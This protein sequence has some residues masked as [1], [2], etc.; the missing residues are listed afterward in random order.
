MHLPFH[1]SNR[2]LLAIFTAYLL[3][4]CGYLNAQS[5]IPAEELMVTQYGV[6]QGLSQSMVSQVMQDQ[7]GLIWMVSGEGLNCFNGEEFR[8]FKIPHPTAGIAENTMREIIGM[9]S[10]QLLISTTSSIVSFDPQDGKFQR[11][12]QR[13]GQYPRIFNV[14]IGRRSL[15]WIPEG[16]YCLIEDR[17]VIPLRLDVS[18]TRYKPDESF[19]YHAVKNKNGSVI[20]ECNNGILV[21]KFVENQADHYVMASWTPLEEGCRGLTADQQ[22][23][24]YLMDGSKLCR[25]NEDGT[26]TQLFDTRLSSSDYL[27]IDRHHNFWISDKIRKKVHYAEGTELKEI[28]FKTQQGKLTEQVNPSII[29]IF[30]DK[31]G[32]LWFGTDGD[33]VLLYTPGLLRFKNAKTGF[34]RSLTMQNGAII[35]GTYGNGLWR[36]SDDLSVQERIAPHKLP[37]DLYYMDLSCDNNERI[38]A[39]TGQGLLVINTE[40]QVIFRLN[41]DTKHASFIQINGDTVVLSMNNDL[42][43]IHAGKKPRILNRRT[44]GPIRSILTTGQNIWLGTPFGLFLSSFSQRWTDIALDSNNRISTS[45][46]FDLQMRNQQIWVATETGLAIYSMDGKP[47]EL[48]GTLRELSKEIFYSLSEDHKHRIWFSGNKG[49]GCCDIPKNKLVYFN[50]RN[51]L[52]SLEFNH[53]AF[54][55]GPGGMLYFGGINGVNAITPPDFQLERAGPEA[56]LFSLLLSDRNISN[57]IPAEFLDVE[58]NRNEPHISGKV[59]STDYQYTGFQQYSFFL[60]GW[61]DQWSSP[62]LS[63]SFSFRN[64]PPG[65][66][67]LF[68]KCRDAFQ[69]EGK[70]SLLLRVRIN[71][72]FWTTWWFIAVTLIT[73]LLITA[74]VVRKIQEIRYRNKLRELE[75]QNAINKERL[76]ISKDMHDEIGASLT[77]ISILSELARNRTKDV[78]ETHHLIDQIND[79]SGNVVDE[80]SEIIWAINPKN[81]SLSSF[82]SYLR[83]YASSYLES[84][85]IEIHYQF[86]KE[87]PEVIMLSELRRNLFLIIKEALHNIVKHSSARHVELGISYDE[88]MLSIYIRDNG[89]GFFIAE[90]QGT[91]NGLINMQKRMEECGGTL[92]M[93]SE[94]GKGCSIEMK[95]SFNPNH[96]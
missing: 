68:V 89:S 22:G 84:T 71:P 80:I 11:L 31:Q 43:V 63:A 81:D 48:K 49:I 57:G 47:V 62:S 30:E 87:F 18:D 86:R 2:S 52:Q 66:Y 67:R 58:L 44:V 24:V 50:Q 56:R 92:I 3:Q 51:N 21:F 83:R 1:C 46:V 78:S 37:N 32:N 26:I 38:W 9:A 88:G 28:I 72:P 33:G 12:F 82:A 96:K 65:D 42:L 79:I 34:T 91:G 13:N 59:F 19:P 61:D 6:E 70:A 14:R 23:N 10:D 54:L 4:A 90:R 74:L 77:R 53:N 29:N 73:I 17:N 45:A 94:P 64:L 35:A 39:L 76:R 40:D 5:R 7:R 41:V 16:G 75:Q 95:F 85:G 55:A 20:I 25:W 8:V 93:L 15:C 36:L 27:Y 60:E 69:N